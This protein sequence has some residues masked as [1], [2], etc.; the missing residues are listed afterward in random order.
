MVDERNLNVVIT[1]TSRGLGLHLSRMFIESG[2]VVFGCSRGESRLESYAYFHES[3][4]I[5]E[6]EQVR[7]W[8]R[9]IK[10]KVGK[11]DVLICSAG[12]VESVL[13]LAMTSKKVFNDF[14]NTNV[15]G[16]FL[17]CREISKVMAVQ[18]Q[19]RIITI[20]S[21]M[22]SL[23]EPGTSAYS[24]S[25]SAI[26]EMTKVLACELASANITC[27]VIA[28]GLIPNDASDSFG[29][30]WKERMLEQQT[31]KRPIT[32]DEIFHAAMYFVSPEAS[33]VTGQTLYLGLVQ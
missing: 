28:P 25:K 7:S 29:D 8:V 18:R 15:L 1:G 4:D 12:L 19:G 13:P 6:E 30:D 16:T 9:S 33:C 22:T 17:V 5:T 3:L 2:A 11:I 23:H 26:Q 14:L 24:S 21:T 20:S 31:I 10:K 32:T 27:N